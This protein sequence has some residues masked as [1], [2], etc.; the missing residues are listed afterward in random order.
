LAGS[1][2]KIHGW[3][4]LATFKI[5]YGFVYFFG[6]SVIL[7]IIIFVYSVCKAY[8]DIF[9]S[10]S[11]ALSILVTFSF[12]WPS[13][14]YVSIILS[15][16][17]WFNFSK[18]YVRALGICSPRVLDSLK[19]QRLKAKESVDVLVTKFASEIFPSL[20]VKNFSRKKFELNESINNAFGLLSEIGFN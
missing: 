1:S 11:D 13:Y 4:V 9:E 12:I 6:F 15:D 8:V 3:D 7:C 16:R 2:V 17:V 14:L 5:I 18:L 20:K 19:S 10:Y